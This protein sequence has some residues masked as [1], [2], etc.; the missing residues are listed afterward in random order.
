MSSWDVQRPLL[1]SGDHI[2]PRIL[3]VYYTFN[4]V[5]NLRD[6]PQNSALDLAT[7]GFEFPILYLGVLSYDYLI[8]PR[9]FSWPSLACMCTQC[10]YNYTRSNNQHQ[11]HAAL[12]T[13]QTMTKDRLQ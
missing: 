6:Q 7:L 10:G 1:H 11:V 8:I 2:V 9:K 13:S 4:I 12:V 3:T 5:E